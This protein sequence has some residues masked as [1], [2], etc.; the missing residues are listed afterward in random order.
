MSEVLI[1]GGAA[2]GAGALWYAWRVQRIRR[3]SRERLHEEVEGRDKR[4][5]VVTLSPALRRYSWA[6][7]TV[8]VAT[9]LAVAL[10]LRVDLVYGVSL[11]VITGVMT[12]IVEQQYA[13][14]RSLKLET[15][16]ANAI[17]LMVGALSAGAGTT[18][19]LDSAARESPKPIQGEIEELLGR[20]RYGES[21]RTVWADL[22]IRVPLETFRL[23][24]TTMSV[25]SEVGGSLAPTLSQ[26]GRAIRD[27]IEIS[28]RIKSQSTEAQAS[29]IG[30]VCITYF[31]GLLMWRTNP[32]H[33]EDFLKHPFGA[34]VTA[35]A[36]VLQALGLV[37]ITKLSQLK[38]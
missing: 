8:G 5:Y 11:G 13:S 7:W 4:Q 33:F 17:D 15:Q 9:L 18:E 31:L 34:N 23:F 35:G 19:A 3:I 10:L 2:A 30:I 27:R 21:P 29:V 16:L 32:Q 6:P 25:H 14:H 12:W 22:T 36:M 28:R 38:F 26:V 37:W 20:I 1:G 24:A